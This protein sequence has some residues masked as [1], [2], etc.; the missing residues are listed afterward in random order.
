MSKEVWKDIDGFEGKY[1]VS[2]LGLVRNMAH[3]RKA[4]LK[5]QNTAMVRQRILK[6]LIAKVGNYYYKSVLLFDGKKYIG[7]AVATLVAKAF[8]PNDIGGNMVV[9]K[10]GDTLNN[11]ADNLQWEKRSTKVKQ[12]FKDGIMVAKCG[13]N[14][15]KAK[16]TWDDV[17]FIRKYAGQISAREMGEMFGVH[18][19]HI[20][21]IIHH[22]RWNSPEELCRKRSDKQC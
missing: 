9:H 5:Q 14:S 20:Y 21:R 8:V 18:M 11:N 4:K 1:Q 2:N 10:D 19:Q 15:G 3:K 16:L 17:C 6:P 7:Y 22:K 13:E 12:L